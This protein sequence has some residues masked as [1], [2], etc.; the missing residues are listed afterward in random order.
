MRQHKLRTGKT[1]LM[2]AAAIMIVAAAQVFAMTAAEAAVS[3]G[4]P[5]AA[6]NLLAGILYPVAAIGLVFYCAVK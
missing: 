6:G 1:I 4:L 3:L 5:A 2:I